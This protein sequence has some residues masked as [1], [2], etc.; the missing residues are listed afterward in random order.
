MED[1]VIPDPLSPVRRS[2]VDATR[3]VA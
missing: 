2:A 3:S 1:T